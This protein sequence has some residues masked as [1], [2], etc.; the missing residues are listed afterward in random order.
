M[1]DKKET[2]SDIWN[3]FM[4]KWLIFITFLV[5]VVSVLYLLLILNDNEKNTLH[6]KD[7]SGNSGIYNIR[8]TCLDNKEYFMINANSTIMVPN[9]ESNNAENKVIKKCSY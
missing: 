4:N 3:A 5:M 2:L 9:Y 8:K 1:S 7:Y 6:V